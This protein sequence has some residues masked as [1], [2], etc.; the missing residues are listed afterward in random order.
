MALL[1]RRAFVA[2][3]AFIAPVGRAVGAFQP[4]PISVEDFIALSSRLTG[5]TD[6]NRAAADVFLKGLL[7]TPGNAARLANPDV[8][9]ERE[10][11]T[12]WY[13]GAHDVR[14]EQ[15]LAT[16]AGALKWRALGI[17][18]PGACAGRFGAWSQPV[19]PSN[20]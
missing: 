6:L 11:V 13:T 4:R 12:A 9:L 20:R 10:I 18:A 2:V 1:D 16:H 17:P 3:V 8:A 7:A 5:H 15:Q 19:R 14:G